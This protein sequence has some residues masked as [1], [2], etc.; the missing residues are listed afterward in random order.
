VPPRTPTSQLGQKF[1]EL[2]N[3]AV[4]HM[5]ILSKGTFSSSATYSGLQYKLELNIRIRF[6]I[7]PVKKTQYHNHDCNS[8]PAN[9]TQK[10]T[11]TGYLEVQHLY[12]PAIRSATPVVRRQNRVSTSWHKYSYYQIPRSMC[13]TPNSCNFCRNAVTTSPNKLYHLSWFIRCQYVA[14][15]HDMN[16]KT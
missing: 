2:P 5:G 7:I 1:V 4:P 14:K 10:Y 6:K 9:A 8:E 16:M 12:H 15:L 13:C 11:R 3:L